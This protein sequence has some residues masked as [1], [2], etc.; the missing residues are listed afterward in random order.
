MTPMSDSC[1]F[2]ILLKKE[3]YRETIPTPFSTFIFVP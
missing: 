3:V 1:F 2:L